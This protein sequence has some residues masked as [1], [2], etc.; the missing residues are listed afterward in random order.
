MKK[1]TAGKRRLMQVVYTEFRSKGQFRLQ[2][3]VD[4]LGVSRRYARD[5]MTIIVAMN[6]ARYVTPS[7]YYIDESHRASY[8]SLGIEL[9]F[10]RN[11]L[12]AFVSSLIR[13]FP[14]KEILPTLLEFTRQAVVT[15]PHNIP[16]FTTGKS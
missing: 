6:G 1:I 9:E 15:D 7:E 3:V 2:D 8:Q 13:T 14:E 5:V 4:F 12:S 16:R 11:D 10:N